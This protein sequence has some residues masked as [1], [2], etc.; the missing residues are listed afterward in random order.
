VTFKNAAKTSKN[1]N[2]SPNALSSNPDQ[3]LP[4]LAQNADESQKRKQ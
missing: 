2:P 4:I 1:E 3:P